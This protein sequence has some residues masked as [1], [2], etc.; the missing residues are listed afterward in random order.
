MKYATVILFLFLITSCAN[1]ELE[2]QERSFNLLKSL[3]TLKFSGFLNSCYN[4]KDYKAQAI[5]D[6]IPKKY[7]DEILAFTDYQW[8]YYREA[9]YKN[10]LNR[11]EEF[12]IVW[13]DI[14]FEEFHY[15][16]NISFG[17]KNL[18]G[19]IFFWYKNELYEAR[20]YTVDDGNKYQ[21]YSFKM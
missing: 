9:E 5:R 10:L 6:N 17:M 8:K 2:I 18:D 3:D 4:L 7:K 11:T 14:E 13:K 19:T 20:I 16:K 12:Q 15:V 21:I 1:K